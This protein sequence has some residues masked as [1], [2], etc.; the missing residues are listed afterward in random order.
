MPTAFTT[1]TIG[2]AEKALNG[3]LCRELAGTGLTEP[4]WVTLVL[5]SI[6]DGGPRDALVA[7]LAA[8]FKTAPADADAQVSAVVARGLVTGGREI[9][10]T[11][12]GRALHGRISG[13]IAEITARLWG[14]L[15]SADLETAGRVLETVRVRADAE[16]A[17]V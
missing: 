3:I 5:T 6:D 13:R 2:R 11:A 7:R 9:A 15:P 8:A 1:Q 12:A 17:A 4:D 14:D 16:L 10:L